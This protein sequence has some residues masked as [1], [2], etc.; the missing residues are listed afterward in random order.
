MHAI[1]VAPTDPAQAVAEINRLGGRP[2]TVAVHIPLNTARPFG[3]R[4]H[5]PIWEACAEHGLPV[6]S[7]IGGSGPTATP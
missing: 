5:D 7:H 3:N 2:D 4:F 1:L 6:V